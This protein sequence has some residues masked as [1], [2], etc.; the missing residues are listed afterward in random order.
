MKLTSKC[1]VTLRT[2][3]SY[4]QVITYDSWLDW[5]A[6]KFKIFISSLNCQFWENITKTITRVKFLR[7]HP[8]NNFEFFTKILTKCN[9]YRN[10]FSG[11]IS[12]MSYYKYHLTADDLCWSL[13]TVSMLVPPGCYPKL[14][15]TWLQT[16]RI[17]ILFHLRLFK[18]DQNQI[19]ELSLKVIQNRNSKNLK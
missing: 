12:K 11:K 14:M 13:H 9:N 15:I 7:I 5:I 8:I 1:F 4:Y 3:T 10:V 17:S 6:R 16:V 18:L 2:M 19:C